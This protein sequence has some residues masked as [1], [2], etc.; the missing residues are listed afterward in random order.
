MLRFFNQCSRRRAPWLLLACIALALELTALWFQYVMLIRPCVMCIYERCALWGI[1]LAGIVGAI[2][3]ATPLRLMA[4]VGWIYSAWQGVH[5]ACEH[6]K[7]QLHPDPFVTCDFAVRFPDW[8]P[9]D[10]I[11][12]SLFAATGDCSNNQWSALSLS[13][14]QWLIII[15]AVALFTGLLILL[16]QPF[17]AKRRDLFFN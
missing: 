14:P 17:G 3:P 4:I 2:A 13:M 1:F 15:F 6:T 12:P 5:L 11:L 10:K 9:L 16:V 8:L 7:I